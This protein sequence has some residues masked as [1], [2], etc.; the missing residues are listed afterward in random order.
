MFIQSNPTGTRHIEINEEHLQTIRQYSLFDSLIDS[1]G[2]IDEQV[3]E[4]L[5]FNIRGI[6]EANNGDTRNLLNLCF[7]VVYHPNM[8]AYGLQQLVALYN[9]RNINKE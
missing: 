2:Y 9:N 4:K 5:K 8:K 6:L 1:N 7:D 3:L